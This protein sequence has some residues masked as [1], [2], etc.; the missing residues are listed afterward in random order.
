MPPNIDELV[1]GCISL[2]GQTGTPPDEEERRVLQLVA[3]P[4]IARRLIA[5]IPEAF[6]FVLAAH[7]AKVEFTNTF[8]AK[9]KQ[10]TW[11]TIE[12]NREPIF[13]AALRAATSMFH[14]GPRDVYQAIAYRSAALAA[15]NKAL[16]AGDSIE[17][18]HLSGP[19]LID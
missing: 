10:G 6:G 5:W 1:T 2:L 13:A 15:V 14:S 16:N 7:I 3:D 4:M 8:S 12:I 19:A 17:G 9:N 11:V 18:A